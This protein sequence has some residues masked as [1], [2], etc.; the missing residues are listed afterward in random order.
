MFK[1]LKQF[2]Q[3][4]RRKREPAKQR[5]FLNHKNEGR[6]RYHCASVRKQQAQGME[7]RWVRKAPR[8]MSDE[9]KAAFAEAHPGHCSAGRGQ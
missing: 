8:G 1:R 6:R 4:A 3:R 9:A 5:H 2:V 7:W